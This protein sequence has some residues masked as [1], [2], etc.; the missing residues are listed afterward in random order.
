MRVFR[1]DSSTNCRKQP[2]VSLYVEGFEVVPADVPNGALCSGCVRRVFYLKPQQQQAGY[3]AGDLIMEEGKVRLKED[4]C[5]VAKIR[6]K[7]SRVGLRSRSLPIAITYC[8]SDE[9]AFASYSSKNCD[10]VST[11]IRRKRVNAPGLR[12]WHDVHDLVPCQGDIWERIK[13]RIDAADQFI[14]FWSCDASK[15]D[16]VKAEKDYAVHVAR[17]RVE[18]IADFI[19]GVLLDNAR[20]P[21]DLSE[22]IQFANHEHW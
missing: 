20:P 8:H 1:I 16:W 13:A 6:I 14:L 7:R 9:E 18:K 21:A 4:G 11:L 3:V 12:I 19:C 17:S 15:S 2:G 22:H 5:D 10:L